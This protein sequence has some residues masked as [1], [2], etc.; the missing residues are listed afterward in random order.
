MAALSPKQSVVLTGIK[1]NSLPKIAKVNVEQHFHQIENLSPSP[2]CS[3]AGEAASRRLL[4]PTE[5]SSFASHE[6]GTT[7]H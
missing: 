3:D 1:C 6:R 4:P 5:T 2:A 7:T